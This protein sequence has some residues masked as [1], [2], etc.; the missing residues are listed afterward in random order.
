MSFRV[1]F[2]SKN[3]DIMKSFILDFLSTWGGMLSCKAFAFQSVGGLVCED[4]LLYI[5]NFSGFFHLL[6]STQA[7]PLG[8][9][10]SLLSSGLSLGLVDLNWLCSLSFISHVLLWLPL[11]GALGGGHSFCSWQSSPCGVVVR[12]PVLWWQCRISSFISS[13]T[14][15]P[16]F[17]AVQHLLFSGNWVIL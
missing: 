9:L 12:A 3:G 2:I 1:P 16:T 5:V 15:Q 8:W 11:S 7:F 14:L 6:L 17:T 10:L 4:N 13:A